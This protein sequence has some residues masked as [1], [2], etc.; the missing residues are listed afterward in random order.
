M[1]CFGWKELAIYS[2]RYAGCRKWLPNGYPKYL[3]VNNIDNSIPNVCPCCG[4]EDETTAHLLLCPDKD[5][6]ALYEQSVNEFIQW[7][8]SADTS[9]LIIEM[10]ADYLN[11]RNTKTMSE[12]YQG[13][14]TNDENGR[15]WR[16]AQEHDL[17]DWQNFVEGRISTLYV[18]I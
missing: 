1:V 14:R 7:M 9:P 6:T 4:G 16:L 5:R 8:R 10:V 15:G 11:A 13:P 12:L 17:L 2:P 3:L 18:E